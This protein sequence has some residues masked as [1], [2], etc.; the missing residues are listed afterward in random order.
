MRSLEIT[1]QNHD[2]TT[3]RESFRFAFAGGCMRD[4]IE[5]LKRSYRA[6]VP[7]GANLLPE[8]PE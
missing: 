1:P 2:V 4:G 7:R 6:G 3:S 8:G 5:I